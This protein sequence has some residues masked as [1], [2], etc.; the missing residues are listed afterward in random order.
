MK[1]KFFLLASFALLLS[2]RGVREKSASECVDSLRAEHATCF[3][4]TRGEGYTVAEVHDP[5][6][7]TRTLHRYV[8]VDR[9]VPLPDALPE[10]TLVRTPLRRV[11]VYS[12]AHSGMLDELGLGDRIVGVCESRFIDL[13]FVRE[14]VS[15]GTI[16]DLGEASSPDVERMIEIAPEA[17]IAS[18]LE[19][20]GYGR[21]EKTGIPIV[22]CVDYMEN[23]PLGR[24]EWVRFMALFFDRMPT[25]DSLFGATVAAY[26][27]LRRLA[28][29]ASDRPQVLTERKYGAS[30]YVPGGRSYMACLLRDAG[31]DPI[32]SETPDRGSVPLSFEAVFDRA[33]SA[34][35]W[36]IKYNGPQ[37]MTYD[38][39]RG[40]NEAYSR[41]SA[42]EN[43][44]I[45]V[46]NTAEVPYY[47][48]LPLHPDRVL[49]DLIRIFHPKL[50]PESRL[51]YY[52]EMDR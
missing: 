26:D 24:A 46:C 16:A 40:E 2:C 49:G 41:F 5:W 23:S 31:A 7:T 29:G 33:R 36:L 18:P 37:R 15:R 32:W 39:L 30:W 12:S 6:D 22:E 38:D 14:G 13:P 48:E 1:A 51:R 47:E 52:H 10:G 25:A 45:F 20:T 27:S 50:L 8:L 44:R 11:V 3:E 21:V 34:R 4:I 17:V 19:N 42:F 35:F 43:R 9:S 28:A